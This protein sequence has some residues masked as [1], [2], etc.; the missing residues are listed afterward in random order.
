MTYLNILHIAHFFKLK[1]YII[2]Q[3]YEFKLLNSIML[4]NIS[5][6]YIKLMELLKN[7]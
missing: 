7:R 1:L 5:E 3:D 4:A 2:L 6:M